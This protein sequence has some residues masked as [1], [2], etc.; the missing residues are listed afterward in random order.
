M[1]LKIRGYT[2]SVKPHTLLTNFV[3]K[4]DNPDEV[5]II[6]SV[7]IATSS[8]FFLLCSNPVLI[9]FYKNIYILSGYASFMA[10]Q[11]AQQPGQQGQNC[12]FC[13]IAAGKIPSKKVYEDEIC[14]AVLDINPAA[15]GHILLLP[16][17]HAAVMPQIEGQEISHMFMV[18]KSLS[19]VLLRALKA[20][21]TNIFVANGALAGQRAPHFMIHIIPRKDGDGLSLLLPQ[22][23]IEPEDM[24]NVHDALLQKMK[25]LLRIPDSEFEKLRQKPV[26]AR[27]TRPAVI[28]ASSSPIATALSSGPNAASGPQ[29]ATGNKGT[30][31]KADLDKISGLFN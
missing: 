10:D 21:G 7:G 27:P 4:F 5:G 19:N 17:K 14:I 16:K 30:N 9:L 18:A 2:R 6:F 8:G 15:S 31:N 25:G 11:P 20:E 3:C 28:P 29:Q 13:S 24:A 1:S 22:R 12:I 26:A 23:A